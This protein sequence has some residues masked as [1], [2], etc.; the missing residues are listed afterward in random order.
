MAVMPAADGACAVVW[1]HTHD[2]A[3]AAMAWDEA[4]WVAALQDDFGHR[5]GAVTAAKALAV[6]PLRMSRMRRMA[7][8]RVVALGNSAHGL[9][10]VAAQ[11]FNLSARDIE[12]LAVRLNGA[13]AASSVDAMDWPALQRG[14]ADWSETRVADARRVACFTD[15]L[16]RGFLAHWRPF[17]PLRS[18]GLVAL[19]VCPPL[20]RAF[21]RRSLGLDAAPAPS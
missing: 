5:L 7:A 10:P 16:A 14:L 6:Y 9:H 2:T 20:R 17:A 4:R 11:G 8:G 19:D 21:V 3:R 18:L 13:R 1:A 15:L 12:T